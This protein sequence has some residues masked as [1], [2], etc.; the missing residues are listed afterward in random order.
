LPVE[1]EVHDTFNVIHL[2][3]FVGTNEEDDTLDFRKNPFQGGGDDGR[4]PSTTT[5][6]SPPPCHM[7]QSQGPWLESLKRIGTLLLMADRPIYTCSKMP[8]LLA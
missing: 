8:K 3:P 5:T 2:S 4:G 6:E 7:G 1:Y